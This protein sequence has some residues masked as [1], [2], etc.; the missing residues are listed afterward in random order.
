M[1]AFKLD[2]IPLESATPLVLERMEEEAV[3]L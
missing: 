3:E 1:T 2:L